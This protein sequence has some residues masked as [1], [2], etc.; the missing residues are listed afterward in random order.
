[1]NRIFL[2]EADPPDPDY[3]RQYA[4]DAIDGFRMLSLILCTTMVAMSLVHVLRW[5]GALGRPYHSVS[6]LTSS[7][8]ALAG[9]IGL[10]A[11]KFVRSAA[12]A[13]LAAA[14]L[15]GASVSAITADQLLLWAQSSAP[16]P[17]LIPAIFLMLML[18]T[19]LMPLRP[20]HV[21]GLGVLLL[22]ACRASAAFLGAPLQGDLMDFTLASVSLVV[23]AAISAQSTSQRIRVH[24]AH[25]AAMQAAQRTEQARLRAVL[26][27]SAITMERLAA[28][29]SHELNT[30]IG[31]LSSASET[32]ASGVRKYARFSADSPMPRLVEELIDA[33]KASAARLKETVARIQRF[34]N[35]DRGAVRLTDVNQLVQ[36]AVALMHPPSAKQAHVKLHLDPTAPIWCR[37]HGLSEAVSSVLNTFLEDGYEVSVRTRASDAAVSLTL[38]AAGGDR[39]PAQREEPSLAFGVVAGRV[40]ATGWELF[41]ARQ[42]VREAGGDLRS[43]RIDSGEQ[44]ITITMPVVA[45]PGRHKGTEAKDAGAA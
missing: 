25:L 1:V 15:L 40:R 29:L 41:A 36:D 34:A 28:S 43:E 31:A 10:R 33:I 38:T 42:F 32:L 20:A 19:T 4:A 44:T 5:E 35:L 26:A 12:A 2:V 37:P 9:A 39:P 22:L 18:G 3:R 45:G 14:V 13:F 16:A 23:S 21:L 30:P 11:S 6:F 8:L 27:E 24:H 17:S 7:V